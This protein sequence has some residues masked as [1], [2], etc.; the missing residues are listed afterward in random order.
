M[1]EGRV[2]LVTGSTRGIGKGV[3][4]ALAR[5]GCAVAVNSRNSI[6]AA[7]HV[8]EE[9]RAAGGRSFAVCA[10]VS[11]E[12]EVQKMLHDVEQCLGPVEVL[13]KQCRDRSGVAS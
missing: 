4:L 12:D 10:D 9:I 11:R 3:A 1:L 6:A 13:V 2:A 7:N 5:A 8:A